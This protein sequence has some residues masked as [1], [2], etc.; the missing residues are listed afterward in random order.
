VG[1]RTDC[2]ENFPLRF[3]TYAAP[4]TTA[5]GIIRKGNLNIKKE[6][7]EEMA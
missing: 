5:R 2:K 7:A 4:H 3:H 1:R 6:G